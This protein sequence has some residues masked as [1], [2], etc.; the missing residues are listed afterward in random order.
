VLALKR[1]PDADILLTIKDDGQGFD[2]ATS[3]EGLGSKLVQAMTLQLNG[4]SHYSF[5]GGTVFQSRFK[6]NARSAS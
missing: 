4:T 5:N 2:P 6:I 3:P 1:Q